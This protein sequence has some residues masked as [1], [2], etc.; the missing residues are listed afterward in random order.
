MM[1]L[2]NSVFVLVDVQGRLAELMFEKD[3]LFRNL[4]VCIRGMRL[5]GVPLIWLEQVPD[6][7]G[8]TIEPLRS[9]L[10]GLNPVSKSAFS[11][12]GEPEFIGALERTARKQVVLAGIETHVCVYQ[13]AMDLLASGYEV[14]VVED[15]VS[16]RT[17]E[18]KALALNKIVS[19]GA[20]LSTVEMIMFELM[21]TTLHPQFRDIL[22]LIK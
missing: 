16:S 12:C 13:T 22:K 5:L 11:C 15:A 7:M 3:R 19:A 14:E 21:R 18:S 17:A 4:E 8:P 10:E 20:R 9:L 6:K 1:M 2:D